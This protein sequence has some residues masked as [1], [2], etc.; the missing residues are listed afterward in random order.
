M[1]DAPD[2]TRDWRDTV[3]LPKTDFP[4][5]AGLAAKEPAILERW[6]KIGLYRK[7]REAR[8][9]RETFLLHD[10]PP[11]AN[12][13]IH[14]GH[15]MNKILKDIVV[16]SQTLLGKDAPYV[17]GWDCHGLPIE[18]K[19][20]EAYRARKLNKDEVDP[21][22][23]RAEC[24]AYAEKWVGVQR[25]Q[26]E[27][28]GVMGDWETPY[29]TMN[30]QSEAIIAGELLK[31]A[32]SGQL[33]RGAKPVMWSPVE[34]T[35]LA[36][37]EVEYE[38]VVSTQID[39]AFQISNWPSQPQFGDTAH[40][41]IWTTTPWTIPV[42]QALAYGT[43][44]DYVGVQFDLG[45][46]L[47]PGFDTNH[48]DF[49]GRN[50]LYEALRGQVF[51]VAE[52]LQA[53]FV[54]RVMRALETQMDDP[55]AA[56]SSDVSV[57]WRGKGSDLADAVAR[58][59]MHHLG[60]FFA[61][62]RPFLPGDFVTTDAG[63]G[64]VHMAPDH[65]EDDFLLCKAHGLDPVF[66]VDGAGMYRADWLWLGGQ[67]S[68]INKKF[69]ASDG[70]I[71]TDLREAGALLAASDD[72]AHSYPHSW[73][74]K[75]KIIF[76]ATPQWFIP[77]DQN[78]SPVGRGRGPL[79]E[80][81]W[82]GEGDTESGSHSP[83]PRAA[84]QLAPLPT[85]EGNNGATL[86]QIALDA[87][88]TTRWVPERS[89]NRIRAMV[90]GRP[91][92]VISRQRAWGVP[93]ALYVNRATGDYLRDPEVNARILQ[94]F[95]T[96]GADAWFQAD[97]QALL[98]EKYDLAD[99][100]VITDILDVWFDSGSTHAF[101]VE[102]RY[103][104]GV[105]ADLYLEGSDQHRGWFQS[106]LLE[107]C[108]TRGRAPYGAVLTHGFA[109]DGNGRKMSKS[110][111][112]VVDPLKI[113]G[114]SGADILRLWVA[115]TDYFE[116]VRIGKEVLAGTGDTY[117]KLRNTFR[118]LLGALDGF[119]ESEKVAVS[120]MPELERYILHKLAELDAELRAA[121]AG[122][123]F[124]RY[125]RAL[126]DFGNET[127]SA[128]FFDIRKDSL[129]CDAHG[130]TKRKAYRT[131]LDT[132][133]HALVRYATP[134]IPFT[135][136]EVWQARYPGEESSVHL[137]EW[138]EVDAAWL[139]RAL[140]LRW[141]LILPIRSAVFLELEA[142]RRDK[143]IR[144][145]LEAEVRIALDSDNYARLGD[146]DWQEILI[147]SLV[148]LA[149]AGPMSGAAAPDKGVSHTVTVTPTSRHK[150]GRCWRHL[151]EVAQDGLLCDRCAGV[152]D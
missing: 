55:K 29:L 109:L 19:V 3:F 71:C 5:K 141:G 73:R 22:A 89:I 111:G 13:D 50:A 115:Q 76:R 53:A 150:C 134:L 77:M 54:G 28:L 84:A 42:N 79:G 143:T 91:D 8:A 17:P 83:S 98:G 14:M 37:A 151:P 108:G 95:T 117:R 51:I 81:E 139:D 18:W 43:D 130:E 66:A 122:Y 102:A 69:V 34:K 128:I 132:L 33:Y 144:S 116:D 67:G 86:R 114:E 107:S 148:T 90:E 15:A 82:E 105:R 96:G 45:L 138:P 126:T 20:E 48:P 63:T 27:R 94:A 113:I 40:A 104:E 58:H 23:F 149:D 129:Y 6:A 152:V 59:P 88:E 44:V 1:T 35:A 124:N 120:E 97:H 62:P 80:A 142:L 78:S 101:V 64:L 72:F 87:I 135:A 9:G 38:D 118:Y 30:Y 60:G 57:V 61:K 131:V 103:G 136:E 4:M 21:V 74:S 140:A 31:F 75:A 147:T 65:G 119:D 32:E 52:A 49:M 106:S 127:L 47:E 133:F 56:F 110:L 121:V 68:V 123:E 24:R 70:P 99:Y 39:V 11:Y 10:G 85:G 137:L 41:V 26:F 146:L 36:E 2:S 125:T 112:N 100:E 12:G 46:E 145:G 93:I 7:L 16:R 25:G 92:W